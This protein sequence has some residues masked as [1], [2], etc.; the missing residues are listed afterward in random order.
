VE[1]TPASLPHLL[2]PGTAPHACRR[3]RHPQLTG[4]DLI[5]ILWVAG[6]VATLEGRQEMISSL[7]GSL[8]I[9]SPNASSDST[10][11]SVHREASGSA[12]EWARFKRV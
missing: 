12:S 3:R 9:I 11:G 8:G 5:N 2:P 4:S 10:G 1:L 7:R 6:L